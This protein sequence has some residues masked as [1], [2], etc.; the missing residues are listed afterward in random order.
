M[1]GLVC[2]SACAER[3]SVSQLGSALSLLSQGRLLQRQWERSIGKSRSGSHWVP[4]C[5]PGGK[6][7]Q[8]STWCQVSSVCLLQSVWFFVYFYTFKQYL[9]NKQ[10]RYGR[11]DLGNNW[12]V[13]SHPNFTRKRDFCWAH[14]NLVFWRTLP[15][16]AAI[17]ALSWSHLLSVDLS[18]QSASVSQKHLL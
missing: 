2:N 5:Q 14:L 7:G 9:H 18:A 16:D 15:P 6:T 13:C 3:W 12:K 10:S 8:R 11:V 1:V 4:D 17:C